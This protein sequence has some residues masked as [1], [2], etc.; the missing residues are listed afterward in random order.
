MMNDDASATGVVNRPTRNGTFVEFFDAATNA[1]VAKYDA[2]YSASLTYVGKTL[3]IQVSPPP[4][5]PGHTYY[6]FLDNGQKM[7]LE[8]SQI[9]FIFFCLGVASGTE[10]CSKSIEKCTFS[11]NLCSR[12]GVKSNQRSQFLAIR[13]LESI[14]I[15]DYI[16]DNLH[17]DGWN[18][19]HTTPIDDNSDRQRKHRR[20]LP[21]NAKSNLMLF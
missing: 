16:H 14:V 11:A 18:S 6:V 4:W 8:E 13:Y 20:L 2:G 21:R 7:C 9:R 10:F 1:S 12:T 5:V 17:S 15:F 3:V 19:D